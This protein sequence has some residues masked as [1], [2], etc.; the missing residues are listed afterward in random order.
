MVTWKTCKYEAKH[1]LICLQTFSGITYQL[2]NF[3]M[4]SL[5]IAKPIKMLLT[6]SGIDIIELNSVKFTGF[7]EKQFQLKQENYIHCFLH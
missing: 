1:C 7:M 5:V 3:K 6:F 2:I 4:S